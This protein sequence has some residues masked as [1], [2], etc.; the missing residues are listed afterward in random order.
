VDRLLYLVTHPGNRHLLPGAE[1]EMAMLKEEGG[2]VILRRDRIV[3][4][5]RQYLDVAGGELI[6]AGRSGILAHRPGH[7]HRRLLR[8]RGE[9]L[10]GA[11]DDLFLGEDRLQ[12]AGAV[13]H[14][15]KGDLA[16]GT[17]GHDP[18]VHRDGGAGMV[19]E[20]G[21]TNGNHGAFG[22]VRVRGES[23]GS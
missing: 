6:A 22:K 20:I 5:R 15:Q 2:A 23:N 19:A 10:P 9:P 14:H 7:P 4:A 16:R 21:D 3:H 11:V 13:P 17:G 12:V 8:E 1:P 18:A